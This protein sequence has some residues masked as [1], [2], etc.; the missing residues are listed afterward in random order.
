MSH[1]IRSMLTVI[2]HCIRSIG[3]LVK[4]EDNLVFGGRLAEYKYYDMDKAIINVLNTTDREL[5]R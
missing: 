1:I 3:L 5:Q 2:L 4:K